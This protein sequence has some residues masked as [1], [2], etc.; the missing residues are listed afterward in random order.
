MAQLQQQAVAARA[1]AAAA[2]GRAAAAATSATQEH[3]LLVQLEQLKDDLGS[4]SAALEQ[5]SCGIMH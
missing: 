4:T 1:A 5:V 3:Q 2:E